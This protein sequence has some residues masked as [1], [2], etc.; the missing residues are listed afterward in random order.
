MTSVSP[1]LTHLTSC[2]GCVAKAGPGWLR[3]VLLPLTS[4]FPGSQFPALLSGLEGTDDAAIYKISDELALVA[5]IDFFPP[6][7][8]DPYTFGAIAATNALSDVF[9][10]GGDVAFA[11]NVAAFPEELPQSTVGE[12]LRGG[13]EKVAE[14]GGAIAGGHT[15]WDEEPKYGLSVIG[16]VHPERVLSKNG[17]REGDVLY[18]TKSIGT[19]TVLSAVRDG[20]LSPDHLQPAID[21]MLLLNRAAAAAAR[22]AQ[23]SAATDVTGFGLLGHLWEMAQG[24]G[25]AVEVDAESYA[26]L[27][28]ALEAAAAG[29]ATSGAGRN[30]AWV[31]ENVTVEAGVRPEREALLFDPQTSGGLILAVSAE[32]VE[33]LDEALTAGGV[34]FAHIGRVTAGPAHIRV[35]GHAGK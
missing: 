20:I 19:G 11:L 23:L 25:V 22:K 26:T 32:R 24:S 4:L 27:P 29:V 30:R 13:A 34:S 2:G 21:S 1:P 10:M 31:G 5:T 8:D 12:I 35:K 18:L 15:I 16:T 14:A 28:G 7:V 3:D 17:L 33:V 9:A 6:L